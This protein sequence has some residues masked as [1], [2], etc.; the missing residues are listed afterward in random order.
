MLTYIKDNSRIKCLSRDINPVDLSK[1][2]IIQKNWCW[3]LHYEHLE[4]AEGG[5]SYP[6]EPWSGD[7]SLEVSGQHPADQ[8]SSWERSIPTQQNQVQSI[9]PP[10]DQNAEV[11]P[12]Y[13]ISPTTLNRADSFTSTG[14]QVTILRHPF[15]SGSQHNS[16]FT[17]GSSQ[18][19]QAAD[20]SGKFLSASHF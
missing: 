11:E 4:M 12:S 13:N 14:T 20:N 6:E 8:S 5:P 1:S 3:D 15:N 10:S 9:P 7:T 2:W 18:T 19:T 16:S 17:P